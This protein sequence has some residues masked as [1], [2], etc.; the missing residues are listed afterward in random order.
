M[1]PEYEEVLASCADKCFLHQYHSI[2]YNIPA[3]LNPK[4]QFYCVTKGTHI[5]V[6]NRWYVDFYCF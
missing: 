5:G 1:D 2:Y 4:A 6:F 3:K